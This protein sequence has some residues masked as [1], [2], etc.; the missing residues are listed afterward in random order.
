MFASG[1]R[2]KPPGKTQRSPEGTSLGTSLT[3]G[4]TGTV[5]MLRQITFSH[6]LGDVISAAFVRRA[7]VNHGS[8][9]V[10]RG[11]RGFFGRRGA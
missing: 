2:E 10:R 9:A 11:D 5:G 4:I 3:S 6:Q 1:E 8:I 7:V